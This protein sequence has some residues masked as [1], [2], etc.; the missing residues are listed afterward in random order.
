[1]FII[2]FSTIFGF[3]FGISLFIYAIMSSTNNYVMFIS[4]SSFLLVMGGT[5]AATMIGYQ[6][7]YVWKSMLSLLSIIGPF[8]LN[9]K[10]LFE[11]T[12]RIIEFSMIA[13][14]QGPLG[15]EKALTEKEKNDPLIG[16]GVNLLT[17][18]YS[19]KEIRKMLEDNVESTF[20]RNMVQSH[21]LSSM[22]GFSPAFGMIGTLVGLV[23]MFES[24]GTDISQIGRGMALALLTTLYGVLIAHL[25]LKP[26]SEKLRQREEIYRFRSLLIVE[27]L[28]MIADGKDSL[29]I[30]DAMNSFLDPSKHFNVAKGT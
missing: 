1:M 19:G 27:G 9:S 28:S 16:F 12:G 25:I 10:T 23:I 13:K 22:S 26:A 18:G 17:S 8:R 4:L 21:I 11:D 30:Q 24:M 3:V 15:I 6:G 14:K 5:I 20:E 2:S 7:R 29:N